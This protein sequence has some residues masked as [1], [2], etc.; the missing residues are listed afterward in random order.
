MGRQTSCGLGWVLGHSSS[1]SHFTSTKLF[2]NGGIKEW[3]SFVSHRLPMLCHLK[4][5]LAFKCYLPGV[6]APPA[7]L[8]GD[9]QSLAARLLGHKGELPHSTASETMKCAAHGKARHSRSSNQ[10]EEEREMH[11][12]QD[13]GGKEHYFSIYIHPSASQVTCVPGIHFD[14]KVRHHMVSCCTLF[15]IISEEIKVKK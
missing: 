10:E 14:L 7:G 4:W 2:R 3:D 5:V 13:R 9:A 6:A 15:H 12:G 1:S 8:C 11:A